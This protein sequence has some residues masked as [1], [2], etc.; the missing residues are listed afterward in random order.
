MFKYNEEDLNAFL[1]YK[2]SIDP[3]QFGKI[4]AQQLVQMLPLSALQ[5][6]VRREYFDGAL[7]A[8]NLQ[9]WFET[10]LLDPAVAVDLTG[11]HLVS[12]GPEGFKAFNQGWQNQMKLV[13]DQNMAGE[14]AS[15]AAAAM[16]LCSGHVLCCISQGAADNR[17]ACQA[18]N[19]CIVLQLGV[20]LSHHE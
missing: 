5:H 17:A 16:G 4:T 9:K 20:C 12:G 19:G 6:H 7:Q 15:M 14:C 1:S 3:D 18:T 13:L 8:A 10:F 11:R 2:Q